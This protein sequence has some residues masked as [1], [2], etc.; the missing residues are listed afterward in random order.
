MKTEN[1]IY[2]VEYN[3]QAFF[4]VSSFDEGKHI[5]DKLVEEFIKKN[6]KAKRFWVDDTDMPR[7]Y[8]A[9]FKDYQDVSFAVRR[10]GLRQVIGQDEIIKHVTEFTEEI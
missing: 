3:T 10:I 9:H 4:H 2:V 8:V 5:V 1:F 7:R 6:P